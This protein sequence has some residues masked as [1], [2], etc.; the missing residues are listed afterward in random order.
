[1]ALL[2]L[3]CGTL[4]KLAR[5][6][7]LLMQTEVG[8]VF[9]PAGAG[10]GGSSTMP[11]KRN[12]VAAAGVLAAA[13]RAPGLVATLLSAMV[14][15]HERGLGGWHAEWVALPELVI[16]AAGALT[17]TADLVAGLEIDP[18]RMR[19]NLDVTHGLIMA[20]AVAMALGAT[21]GKREAH[22]LVEAACKRAVAAQR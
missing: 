12:P 10:R 7:S 2:G 13:V 5:D 9:E 16:L 15:E 20:E 3:I 18:A 17:Q 11:H 6:V 4:G 14:Q 8:E 19:A 1:A 21:L 22:H